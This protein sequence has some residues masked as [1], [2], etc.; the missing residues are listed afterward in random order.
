MLKHT[1]LTKRRVASFLRHDLK[2][3][4]HSLRHPLRIEINE[5]PCAS[6]SEAAKGPWR[7]VEKGFA[8]G[9]AY[10]TF[11]FRLSGQVPEE[12]A[13]KPLA[14]VAEVGGERTVWRDDSP[15]CGVDHEHSDFGWLEGS[16]MS[17]RSV[18]TGGEEVVYHVQSHTRNAQTTVHGKELPRSATSETVD[19]A[20]LVVVDFEIRDLIY[21]VD[22]A[23]NLLETIEENDPAFTTILRALNEVVNA[24]AATGRGAVGRCRKL[25][26]DALGSLN[27]EIKHTIVPVGH[28]HLDTAWLWPI[29]ITKKK[30]AHTT[31]TQL[32]LLER[33][34]EYIFVHSQASQYE[35]L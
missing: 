1:D 25:V 20:E 3:R 8:Y 6:E 32:G 17:E 30:M 29:H 11:W 26:R 18:A 16:A 28:A 12:F 22:F 23:L 31:A 9:P 21:D 34:P 2:P 5:S 33:Y 7:E 14:V 10:T 15:W 27:G 24:F 19:R 35:W 4:V 13:G